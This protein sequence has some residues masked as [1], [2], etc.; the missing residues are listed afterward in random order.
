MYWARVGVWFV[1]AGALAACGSSSGDGPGGSAGSGA[2][3]GSSAAA[4]S[5]GAGG[6][7]ASSAGANSGGTA[8]ANAAGTAGSAMAGSGNGG[9]GGSVFGD[10]PAKACVAYA[11]ASCARRSVCEG[12]DPIA[13][14]QIGTSCPDVVFSDVRREPWRA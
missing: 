13:C 1:G 11:I 2:I 7:I 9:S 3:G 10:T 6:T 4:G 8:G 12:F 14:N 5:A